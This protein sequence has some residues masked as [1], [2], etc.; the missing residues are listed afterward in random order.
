MADNQHDED[1]RRVRAA[2]DT[3]MEHFD[4]VHVFVTRHEAGRLDGTVNAH[5]GAG[6]WFT[7][8]GQIVEWVKKSDRRT[9][10]MVDRESE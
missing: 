3:L 4:S 5:Y 6:N 9:E 1:L 8:Y 2:C 7:R 10:R